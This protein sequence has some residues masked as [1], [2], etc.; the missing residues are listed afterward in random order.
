LKKPVE[1]G[2]ELKFGHFLVTVDARLRTVEKDI[3]AIYTRKTDKDKVDKTQRGITPSN[4]LKKIAHD[5]LPLSLCSTKGRRVGLAR[6]KSSLHKTRNQNESSATSPTHTPSAS[7]DEYGEISLSKS[8][9][10]R[11]RKLLSLT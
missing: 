6:L 7:N 3:S 1:E 5:L 10:S 4:N 8:V 9:G 11:Q 2:D